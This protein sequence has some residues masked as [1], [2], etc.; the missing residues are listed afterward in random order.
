MVS[1]L[2]D[3]TTAA[4][5]RGRDGSVSGEGYFLGVARAKAGGIGQ[6]RGERER[7]SVTAAESKQCLCRGVQL[8]LHHRHE[9]PTAQLSHVISPHHCPSWLGIPIPMRP[10]G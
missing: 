8:R 3:E 6:A 10:S 1:A 7:D 9:Q 5:Q 4:R 2:K